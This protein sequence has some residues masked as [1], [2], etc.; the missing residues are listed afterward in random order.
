MV[1]K[2]FWI[3]VESILIN[4][5]DLMLKIDEIMQ[6]RVPESTLSLILALVNLKAH[7]ASPRVPLVHP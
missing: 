1:L 4:Y 2:G 7:F 6:L 3:K 5:S